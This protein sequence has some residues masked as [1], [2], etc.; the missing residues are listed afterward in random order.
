M[1]LLYVEFVG[2]TQYNS[3][4]TTP[5]PQSWAL[6]LAGRDVVSQSGQSW[7]CNYYYGR[8]PCEMAMM[9]GFKNVGYSV[10]SRETNTKAIQNLIAFFGAR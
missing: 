4:S 3:P 2:T 8:L 10:T 7:T 9:V 1:G 5:L 6:L